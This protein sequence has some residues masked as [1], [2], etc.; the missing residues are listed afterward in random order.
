MGGLG[1]VY[2]GGESGKLKF[3]C[4]NKKNGSSESY[5]HYPCPLLA[6]SCLSSNSP[7]RQP[8]ECVVWDW[9]S[10][11]INLVEMEEKKGAAMS[12]I[13]D[14]VEETRLTEDSCEN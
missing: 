2:S 13:Q 9:S 6:R 10:S 3:R 12:D 1:N 14:E 4:I 8:R 11:T 5:S 7:C